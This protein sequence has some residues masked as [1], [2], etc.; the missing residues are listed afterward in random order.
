MLTPTLVDATVSS[1][2]LG[3]MD[4]ARGFLRALR[5]FAP[6]VTVASIRAGQSAKDPGRVEPI[7]DGLRLAG[8]PEE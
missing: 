8:M 1:A 2:H 4:E 3:R 6:H 5:A 7:L